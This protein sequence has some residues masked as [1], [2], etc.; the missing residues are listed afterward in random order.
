MLK[1]ELRRAFFSKSFFLTCFLGI[2]M[3][4]IG[5][6]D[7]VLEYV[8]SYNS[9]GTYLEKFLVSFGYGMTSL[10]AVL[11]PIVVMIP[12]VLSYRR[13]RDSGYQN[14]MILKASR[15][16]YQ[17]AKIISVEVSGFLVLFLP[18]LVWLIFCYYI[19]GTGSTRY[20]II[21]GVEFADT[22][23]SEYPFLYGIIYVF[24]AGVQGAVFATLGLGLSTVLRNRYLAILIPFSYCIFTAS[25]LNVYSK[26]FNALSLMVIGQYY[27]KM[28]GHVG[29]IMYDI[30]LIIIGCVLFIRGDSYVNKA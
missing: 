13:E 24:N 15:K 12:Y 11:F 21:Y 7:F 6:Y 16:K 4:L 14:L 28:F 17:V 30:I 23:Y 22:L 3:L 9:P 26:A 27:N 8:T 19:L 25:V 2:L 18:S 5:G 10:L 20:P 29:I 1:V